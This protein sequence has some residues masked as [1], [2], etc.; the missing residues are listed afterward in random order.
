MPVEALISP[1]ADSISSA[2]ALGRAPR[3]ALEGH[4]FEEMGDAVLVRL[5][6]A[7][8]GLHPDAERHR[9]EMRHRMG[10]DVKAVGKARNFDAHRPHSTHMFPAVQDESLHCFRRRSASTD[11]FSSA[12]MRRESRGG[13]PGLSPQAF[14]TASG[15]FAGMGGGQA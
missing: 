5:F 1:P 4:V 3:G 15:N 9:F 11:N 13:K 2:I 10:N 12:I 14:S 6:V 7:G 8:A